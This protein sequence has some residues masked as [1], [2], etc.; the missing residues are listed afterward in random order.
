MIR[1]RNFALLLS[2]QSPMAA[3]STFGGSAKVGA[4]QSFGANQCDDLTENCLAHQEQAWS[5]GDRCSVEQIV[6]LFPILDGAQ[7][8]ETLL[9]QICNEVFL[10][11]ERGEL[12]SL[13]EYQERFPRLADLLQ[14]QWEIDGV[15]TLHDSETGRSDREPQTGRRIDRYEILSELRRGAMGVVYLAWDP[16]LKRKVALKRLRTGAD[17]SAE[18]VV[19]IRTEAEAIAQIQHPAIVQIFD[20]GDVEELPYLAMEHC[21]GGT[22]ANPLAGKPILPKLAA[23]LI[24]QICGG[25]VA[26]HERRI[27]PD[28]HI[29]Q[30][31]N[32]M[33]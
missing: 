25:V 13:L 10:R 21:A 27:I 14:T 2:Q 17:S 32:S 3:D 22:L 23:E 1:T 16:Q 26:A 7:E 6:Q 28:V 29:S 24:K 5:S 15:L 19:R 12:P 30:F 31:R 20:V 11:E 33:G 18:E 8:S 9:S 4:I